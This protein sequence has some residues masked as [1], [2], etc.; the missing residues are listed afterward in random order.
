MKAGNEVIIDGKWAVMLCG[1]L[2]S[3]MGSLT[4]RI[5]KPLLLVHGRPIIWYSFW[6][7]HQKGFRNFILPTGYLGH[8]IKKYIRQMSRNVSC[9]IHLVDTGLDTSIAGRI[10][11]VCHLIPDDEDF[12]LLNTDTIFDF[13]IESMYKHHVARE[14]LVTLSS[15]EIVSPWGVLT[16]L[17]DNVIEFDRNRKVQKLISTHEHNGYGVVNSGLAWIKRSAL[18]LLEFDSA[19]DFETEL[20]GTAIREKKIAHFR[21]DGIWL[22]IDTPK[23]LA[24]IN[25]P[26]ENNDNEKSPIKN[27][28]TKFQKAIRI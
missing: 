7:L 11:Q 2:G 18:D 1:G 17:G 5:P 14:A 8:E 19:V 9:N 6:C 22:P 13:D 16:I 21:L 4:E 24:A 23:D 3:R 27:L 25:Y 15:V 28:L 10:K 20:F 12:F 26:L